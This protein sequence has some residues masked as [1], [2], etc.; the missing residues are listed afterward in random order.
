MVL[1]FNCFFLCVH[2]YVCSFCFS[3]LVFLSFISF[4][5][6][7]F[8]DATEDKNKIVS[9]CN[10]YREGIVLTKNRW[11]KQHMRHKR[12]GF[13]SSQ[14]PVSQQTEKCLRCNDG[15]TSMIHILS[16]FARVKTLFTETMIWLFFRCS[17]R[18]VSVQ[19]GSVLY[20]NVMH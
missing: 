3:R 1:L 7:T 11:L 4:R 19:F 14:A 9:S 17:V 8:T 6:A 20:C 5:F 12:G 10:M 2:M 13:D 18:F 15:I 16:H